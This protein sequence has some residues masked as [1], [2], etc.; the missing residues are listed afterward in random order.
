MVNWLFE[1]DVTMTDGCLWFLYLREFERALLL[2]HSLPGSLCGPH[3]SPPPGT[4]CGKGILTVVQ[5]FWQNPFSFFA[6][7]SAAVMFTGIIRVFSVEPLVSTL[8]L[9]DITS[10]RKTCC[11]IPP[12]PESSPEASCCS[13]SEFKMVELRHFSISYWKKPCC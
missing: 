1:L 9:P 3:G 7:K 13:R 10:Q 12:C 5:E 4:A 6:G 2:M 11:S 8:R